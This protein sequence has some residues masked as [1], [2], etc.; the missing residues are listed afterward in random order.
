MLDMHVAGDKGEQ[1]RIRT[2]A[3]LALQM[4][5]TD[6]RALVGIQKCQVPA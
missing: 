3:T 4:L 2:G 1:E 5:V 6:V